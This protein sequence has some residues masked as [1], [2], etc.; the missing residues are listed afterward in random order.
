MLF[1]CEKRVKENCFV[2]FD[3]TTLYYIFR[4]PCL[5]Y[6]ERCCPGDYIPKNCMFP[7]KLNK[8]CFGIS[9]P[10]TFKI[11]LYLSSNMLH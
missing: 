11:S 1:I 3:Y 2:K 5:K 6:L 4:K 9:N 7:I 10:M 8:N